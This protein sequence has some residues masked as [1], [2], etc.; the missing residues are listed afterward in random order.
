MY[1]RTVRR[2]SKTRPLPQ[3]LWVLSSILLTSC[4]KPVPS[5]A[6]CIHNPGDGLNMENEA[7][8]EQTPNMLSGPQDR[9]C[10]AAC[11][12]KSYFL[13]NLER[14]ESQPASSPSRDQMKAPE[15]LIHDPSNPTLCCL[16]PTHIE[17]RPNSIDDVPS[18]R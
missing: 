17:T 4:R 13:V 8:K 14:N 16:N 18:C 15:S 3:R 2:T 11:R 12:C 1:E 9:H 7:A 5:R 6:F 10:V